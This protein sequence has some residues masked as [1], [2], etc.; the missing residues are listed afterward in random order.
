MTRER[1]G[2]GQPY[3][4]AL[5]ARYRYRYAVYAN[6]RVVQLPDANCSLHSL[7]A[8]MAYNIVHIIIVEGQGFKSLIS[9]RAPML[10]CVGMI[11]R[12]VS[13]MIH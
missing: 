13:V 5:S 6:Q 1:G 9:Y 11:M 7:H 8:V 2:G 4:T 3:F 12:M 10:R